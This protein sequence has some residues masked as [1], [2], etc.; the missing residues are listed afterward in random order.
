MT[1]RFQNAYDALVKGFYNG[2]LEKGSCSACA[3]GNIVR[4]AEGLPVII[5]EDGCDKV[6]DRGIYWYGI[7]LFIVNGSSVFY[8]KGIGE[9]VEALTG[10]NPSDI[11]KIEYAFESATKIERSISYKNYSESEIIADQYNGLMAVMD[12]LMELDGINDPSY[13]DA[14]KHHPELELQYA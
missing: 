12:V 10:Y 6:V 2:T 3:V 1:K 14:F 5:H 8:E 11:A 4:H 9:K 7:I 13:K